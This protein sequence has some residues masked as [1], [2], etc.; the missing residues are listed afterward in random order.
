MIG[1]AGVLFNVATLANNLLYIGPKATV[2]TTSLNGNEI[3]ATKV[4][5]GPT[6]EY[7]IPVGNNKTRVLTGI[8]TGYLFGNIDI[9]GFKQTTSGFAANAYGGVEIG[10][11]KH[12]A[13]GVILNLFEYNNTTFKAEEGNVSNT[14]SN[15]VFVTDRPAILIGVRIDLNK[16]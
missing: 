10:L 3:K 14:T 4:L 12:I 6:V 5:I 9:F 1:A 7:Q 2:N 11:G 15:T 8:N 13:L 16:K